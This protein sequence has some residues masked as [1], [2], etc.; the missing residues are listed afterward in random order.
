MDALNL[1]PDALGVP[2]S[3]FEVEGYEDH[4]EEI[5]NAYP[6]EDFRTPAEQAAEE[7]VDPGAMQQ[8]SDEAFQEGSVA[9]EQ[10][11][12]VAEQPSA[13]E[14]VEQ[15]VPEEAP[16]PMW[17]Y[18]EEG[19]I[20]IEQ[21][22]EKLGNV[23]EGVV[24]KLALQKDWDEAKEGR[25]RELFEDG[26]NLEAQLEA[27][28]MIR[29][30]P[31]LVSRYDHNEDGEITYDDFFDTTNDPDWSDEK[32][33][34]LTEE[35]LAGLENKDVGTRLRA[36]WQQNGAGQNMARY[37]NLRRE[38]ALSAA[39]AD[40]RN[41]GE[42]VRQN[43]AGGLFDM[44]ATGLEVAGS[45]GLALQGKNP[46]EN[47]TLDEDILQTDNE[48]SLEYLVNNNIA[49][50]A[51]DHVVYEAG[52]WA[53]P[54]ILTAG[55]GSV[56]GGA[57]QSTKIP[58]LVK[59]GQFLKPALTTGKVVK[60]VTKTGKVLTHTV[61][62][63]TGNFARNTFLKTANLVKSAAK[64]TLIDT[65]PF[66]AFTDLEEKGRGAM[67]EDGFF[68]KV[69]DQYPEG[70]AFSSQLAKGLN[71]PLFKQADFMATE[72]A[73]GVMGMTAVGGFG[74]AI[75]SNGK[76]VLGTLPEIPGKVTR[77]AQENLD[78]T[79]VSV[80]SWSTKINSEFAN[81]EAF[82]KQSQERLSDI[83]EAAS[84]QMNKTSEGF[85]NVFSN[86][87]E[88]DGVMKSA[89]GAYKNGS[90][91]L[92]QGY[93]KARDGIRQVINDIDEIRHTVGVGR[94][95]STNA[96]FNQTAMAK[97][98]KSGIPDKQLDLFAKDLIEDVDYKA[99]IKSLDP[100]KRRGVV[101]DTA[102]AGIKEVQGRNAGRT[103]PAEYWGK[104]MDEPLNIDDFSKA[105][106]FDKWAVKNVQVQDAV[107][108]SLLM[109]LRDQ[110]NAASEM[111]G[112]TDVFAADGVMRRVGDNLTAG[113]HQVKKTQYTWDAARKMMAGNQGKMTPE[114]LIELNADVA[115]ASSRLHN[116]TKEGVNL[117]VR[118]LQEG[119]D[120]ELAGAVLDVFKV[121]NDVHNW[122]DFDAFMKQAIV[123][124]KFNG[125]VKTGDLVHG[126]QK[127]MVQS[128]LSGPKTP[129]RALLGTT[130]NS[131]LNTIN[132]AFGA[133][134]RAPFTNDLAAKKVAVAKLKGQF[135][136][137]PEAM[138]VFRKEW[139]A[140]F[141]ADIADIQTRYTE[142]GSPGDDLWEAKRVHVEQRGTPGEKA[143]FYINN[144]TRNLTN[145]KL[146][147]WSPRALAATDDTFKWLTARSRSKELGMRAALEEVGEDWSKITPEILEK[148]EDLHMKNFLDADGNLDF[149]GDAWL[150][151]SFKEVT[152]TSELKGTAAK[153]DDVFNSIPMIKPFY[154]FAR[155][156]VNGLNFSYKN[157]P[158]LG[159]LHK[160]SIAILKHTGD[161]FTELAEYGIKNAA[162]LKSARNLFA[163]RQ[164]MGAAVVTT[165]GGMYMGGQLTGNGPA[166]R[167]LR[168]QWINA[169]WKPNHFYIGDVGLDYRT[170]E[171]YNVIFSTIADIG[172]NMELMGS[173]WA[174]KRLQAVGFVVGRGLTG[175]TYMS[176]LDQ[177]MQIMQMKPGAL[178]KAGAN[179][180]NNSI[181]LAGMRN[182]FGKWIN[183]HMKELNSD[184][185]SSIRNRNQASEFLAA[186]PLPAK[187]DLLNG[188]PINNWNIIGRSFN[189]VSPIQLDIRND[190]P[191]RKLLLDSNYD[192]KST[193]YAYGGYSFVKDAH[194]RAHFQN[195]IGTVPVTV[196]FK[197]FKNVEEAL[198]H[199]A[200]RKDVKNS[201][202]DM[203][204]DGGNP[205]NW[206][207]DPNT[208]PHN[209]L[210][211]NLMNQARAKAWAKINQEDH[212]GYERVMKL[213]AEKDGKN[214]KTR[215]NRQE[216]LDLSFPK[217]SIDQF[218]KN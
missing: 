105:S 35:W 22:Q 47:S 88:S 42:G 167:Q 24:R 133:T 58:A 78:Q 28:K 128:I 102:L 75:V 122:K 63:A 118:M 40:E 143:A 125:K 179:I 69:L 145:N 215:D 36:L 160:E 82:F 217:Q 21:L 101:S 174:E 142:A 204:R 68:K 144:V 181:P 12:D 73:Y 183:P 114:M 83:A 97:A 130:V 72:M 184:M 123:G 158:L 57:A 108:R 141:N 113:L 32:D 2:D 61:T 151:K 98:A 44:T 187:S 62:P 197:K 155:T 5:E 37:I 121:S 165:M 116:E 15:P 148:A 137:I 152:L 112:K 198:N 16:Q 190:T 132:E 71:S 7:Q 131:Y 13:P 34:Q 23:P 169:G 84:E 159:A 193:T 201:M 17:S 76:R 79:A 45:V 199:L 157:T 191:G 139:N 11:L 203:K 26:N 90:A 205:A 96:L 9:Q 119:G 194:V 210:I 192:L 211:D 50:S 186:D 107:N 214:A 67:Y 87:I 140:K 103:S 49:R 81:Q 86:S 180:L 207:L 176:G 66:A 93:S 89:Y 173:E 59:A 189:A 175:K 146:F 178:N 52:Y 138:Q 202:E 94:P 53:I 110:A 127:V 200:T 55:A 177:L 92:G 77:F 154:L 206:D 150:D 51:M 168:Q 56:V 172:D 38:H 74:K 6:E 135:E 149:S 195:A 95:G 216:I 209:T 99:Q 100:L 196:G 60:R 14:Q 54:T 4:V 109:Q 10:P 65:M 8:A 171:P 161:D 33:A 185:W 136:L 163:G 120:E 170:L 111:I 182:E 106:D 19:N 156:G 218:P 166:D 80:R 126:L 147:G 25:L 48:N 162:D 27:F 70:A 117:M 134:L 46:F 64:T 18:D 1:Q 164:A 213:K 129:G 124:G 30:D 153:L 212:P 31:E 85:K 115:R 29:D 43:V 208:Y 41:V 3:T 91:M 20:P 39:G 188:K 104:F